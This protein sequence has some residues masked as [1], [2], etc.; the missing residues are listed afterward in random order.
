MVASRTWMLAAVASCML[1]LCFWSWVFQVWISSLDFYELCWMN[2]W[3]QVLLHIVVERSC[4]ARIEVLV[5][6]FVSHSSQYTVATH[7]PITHPEGFILGK[8]VFECGVARGFSYNLTSPPSWFWIL[9]SPA[10]WKMRLYCS[11]L[12][13]SRRSVAVKARNY[14]WVLKQTCWHSRIIAFRIKWRGRCCGGD[15]GTSHRAGL[16]GRN[17]LSVWGITLEGILDQCWEEGYV[18]GW[19]LSRLEVPPLTAF[20]VNVRGVDGRSA[21]ESLTCFPSCRYRRLE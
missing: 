9:R 7:V 12:T 13:I 4:H 20:L 16:I 2:T 19:L 17:W 3:L 15:W 6:S 18:S 10:S 11:D 21:V 5:R 1:L 8:V 14:Q